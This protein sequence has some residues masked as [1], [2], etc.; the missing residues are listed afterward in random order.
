MPISLADKNAAVAQG[1]FD[2]GGAVHDMVVGDDVSIGGDDH[3]AANAVLKLR[4]LRLHLAASPKLALEELLH[5]VGQTFRHSLL[6]HHRLLV[7]FGGDCDVDDGRGD[8]RG[9]G[10]HAWSSESSVCDLAV[11]ERRGAGRDSGARS[12][13]LEEVI[14]AEAGDHGSGQYDGS[15]AALGGGYVRVVHWLLAPVK[16]LSRYFVSLQLTN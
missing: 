11:V 15:D 2:I 10:L 12:R 14:S 5:V 8:A 9:D 16:F 6:L 13:G 3:S 1:D 4:L 7:H